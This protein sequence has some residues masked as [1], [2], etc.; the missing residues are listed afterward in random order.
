LHQYK[1]QLHDLQEAQLHDLQEKR[2]QDEIEQGNRAL[3][4]G[5]YI[6]AQP[7]TKRAPLWQ[8]DKNLVAS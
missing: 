6:D 2:A 8:P 1:A 3:D 5:D 7:L 4:N